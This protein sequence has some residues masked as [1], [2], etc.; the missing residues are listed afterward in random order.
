MKNMQAYAP[1]NAIKRL[2]FRGLKVWRI[3]ATGF[4]F[5]VF[6]LGGVIMAVS[7][8]PVC[9]LLTR[10]CQRRQLFCRQAYSASFKLYI[11]MMKSLGL[12]TYEVSG[13]E[14]LKP[15]S[16]ILANHPSLLDVVFMISLIPEANCL[17]KGSLYQNIFTLGPISA[18]GYINNDAK[19]LIDHCLSELSSGN[20]LLIFPE[21]TRSSASEPIKFRRGAANIILMS[22]VEVSPAVITCTPET[23]RKE[24]SWYSVPEVPP[25][26]TFTILPSLKIDHLR[27]PNEPQSL[28]ARK[29]TRLLENYFTDSL[30]NLN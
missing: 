21:G 16:I 9:M 24:E 7:V 25:H 10:N 5:A 18:C 17:I 4:S 22:D 12:L 14:N 6:G 23:L 28:R 11:F 15:G 20:Q 8:A 2:D 30:G 1:Y 27:H 26:F 19:E 29:L 3:L 13:L